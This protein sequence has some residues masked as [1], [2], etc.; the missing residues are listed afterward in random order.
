MHAVH[1]GFSWFLA[2]R[3]VSAMVAPSMVSSSFWRDI[4]IILV[5]I[6]AGRQEVRS[7][8]CVKDSSAP[9]DLSLLAAVI[10]NFTLLTIS[11]G[12]CQSSMR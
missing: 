12:L 2:C 5:V 9:L 7:G 11:V 3:L 1:Q 10:D 6:S 8:L 4:D